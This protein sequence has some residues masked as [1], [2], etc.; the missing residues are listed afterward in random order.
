MLI[1]IFYYLIMCFLII[2]FA[3][4]AFLY[5]KKL[6]VLCFETILQNF[7]TINKILH[8]QISTNIK[9][10]MWNEKYM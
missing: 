3:Y 2:S 6:I 9:W 10:N 8:A 1:L 7:H 4:L 5:N